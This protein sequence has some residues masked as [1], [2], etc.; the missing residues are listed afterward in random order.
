MEIELLFLRL[1][2]DMK[3]KEPWLTK[4]LK[5]SIRKKNKLYVK[6]LKIKS[7]QSESCYKR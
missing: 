6:Y 2:Y 3:K 5:T 4:A 1:N 7:A